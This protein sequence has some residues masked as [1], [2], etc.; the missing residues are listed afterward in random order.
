MLKI[1]YFFKLFSEKF[2]VVKSTRCSIF[3]NSEIR[4]FQKSRT[5]R[6][7]IPFEKCSI[8]QIFVITKN[9]RQSQQHGTSSRICP[10]FPFVFLQ[11]IVPIPKKEQ[12]SS[13]LSTREPPNIYIIKICTALFAGPQSTGPSS[14]STS[15]G[16]VNNEGSLL[17]PL[18]APH[19]CVH[20]G[21]STTRQHCY[22]YLDALLRA[23]HPQKR[24]VC[25]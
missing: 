25:Y 22:L 16:F 9:E 15:R 14:S 19:Y 13:S 4:V 24:R 21:H 8:F 23:E 12:T 1:L 18:N 6:N 20:T 3:E 10:D 5:F 2:G 11:V 17:R 7:L